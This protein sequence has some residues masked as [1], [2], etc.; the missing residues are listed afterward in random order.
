MP[1]VSTAPPSHRHAASLRYDNQG[2]NRRGGK[3]FIESRATHLYENN[4][5]L[6]VGFMLPEGMDEDWLL[7]LNDPVLLQNSICDMLGVH[8]S[9]YQMVS[10]EILTVRSMR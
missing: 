6:P 8:R 2:P 9:L 3:K 5:V 10:R 4:Y 7:E 1:T